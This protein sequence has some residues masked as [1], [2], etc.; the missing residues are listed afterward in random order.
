MENG[1]VDKLR[2]AVESIWSTMLG[3][4]V[5]PGAGDGSRTEISPAS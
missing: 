1:E 5:A 4:E 2:E 3:M